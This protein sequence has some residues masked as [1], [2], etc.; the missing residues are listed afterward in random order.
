[1]FSLWEE[2]SSSDDEDARWRVPE[3]VVA[4]YRSS[5]PVPSTVMRSVPVPRQAA[6][7]YLHDQ[8]G[9]RL[10]QVRVQVRHVGG[11]VGADDSDDDEIRFVDNV[12]GATVGVYDG[13][14]PDLEYR[15][16][17]PVT[18]QELGEQFGYHRAHQR[19]GKPLTTNAPSPAPNLHAPLDEDGQPRVIEELPAHVRVE[20]VYFAFMQSDFASKDEYK[21]QINRA[22]SFVSKYVHCEL[23]F[24]LRNQQTGLRQRWV[25]SIH[26][27][28][29]LRFVKD[30]VYYKPK[31]WTFYRYTCDEET[32]RKLLAYEFSVRNTKFN[33]L[34][35]LWNF[36]APFYALTVDAAGSVV[37]CSENIARNLRYN[38]TPLGRGLT[39][40]VTNPTTLLQLVEQSPEFVRTAEP[41]L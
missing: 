36:I 23:V 21:N 28:K 37:F 25:S 9:Q 17:E 32:G 15:L 19:P 7:V 10:H 30:R 38:G 6:P 34:G 4:P 33:R 31:L 1:M 2:T 39:P 18:E 26:T 29:Q 27:G 12:T 41:T 8:A 35:F 13:Y 11:N 5:V 24:L 14:D 16:E 22:V 20:G 3:H 40:H